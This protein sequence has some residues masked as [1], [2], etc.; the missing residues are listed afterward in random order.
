MTSTLVGALS[1]TEFASSTYFA[2]RNG[3]TDLV[4]KLLDMGA[5]IDEAD[6]DGLTALDF[7]TRNGHTD[8]V[9][10]LLDQGAKVNERDKWTDT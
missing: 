10:W 8:L 5:F 1:S 4:I 9:S 2:A 3:Y 7:A 6:N